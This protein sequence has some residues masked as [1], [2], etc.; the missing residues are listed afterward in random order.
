MRYYDV[1]TPLTS[2]GS[3][4]DSLGL[5]KIQIKDFIWTDNFMF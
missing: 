4:T 1:L 3:Q 5:M 2:I